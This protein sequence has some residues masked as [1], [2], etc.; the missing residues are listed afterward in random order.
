[1]RLLIIED[2]SEILKCM[3]IELEKA[4]LYVD[5]ACN[6]LEGEEKAYVNEYDAILL[7]L[8]LPDK[9]GIEILKYLR[10]EKIET[11]IIIITA[12]TDIAKGLNF[13]ADDY[14][15][16]PFN[17]DELYARI[18]AVLRR[19]RGRGNP[20]II[21][22]KLVVDP[23]ARKSSYNNIRLELTAK[24]FDILEYLAIRYPAIVSSEEILEHIY[25]EFFD[26][27]S[28]VLRV[29][30]AKLRKKIKNTAGKDILLTTRGRGYSLALEL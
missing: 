21:L 23:I 10:K 9:N 26:S 20:N 8:N 24:E 6:G 11:P 7:D 15:I 29:H 18:Q 25:D 13:G 17:M 28:S 1:M 27:F 5:I 3:K 22:D 2:N 30:I 16:K 4:G 14:I 12:S 19:F